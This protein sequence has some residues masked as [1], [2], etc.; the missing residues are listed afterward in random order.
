MRS[1]VAPLLLGCAAASSAA[2][3][4]PAPPK[5]APREGRCR[6]EIVNVDRKGVVEANTNYYGG[7]NVFLRCFGQKVSMKSDSVR[8]IGAGAGQP[9]IVYFIGNVLY[10]DTTMEM[11]ARN[12]T[13]F[14]NGERWEARDNVKTRNLETGSTLDGPSLDY[15]RTAPGI[16]DTAEMYAVG[17]PTIHYVPKSTDGTEEEPYVIIGDRVRMRGDD[18]LWAGGNVTVD[19][20]DFS[21]KSD[22]LQLF[23]SDSGSGVLVGG[24]PVLKGLKRDTFELHGTRIE[25]DLRQRKVTAVRALGE[26]H[27]IRTDLDLTA[28][29]IHMSLPEEKLQQT[30]A[31][32]AAERAHAVGPSYEVRADSLVIDTPEEKLYEVRGFGDGWM[33][34]KPDSGTHERDWIAGDTV[35]ALFVQRDS[36][37]TE[38]TRIAQLEATGSGRT[39]YRGDAKRPGGPR[40]LNYSRADHIVARMKDDEKGGVERVDLNGNV[41]GVQLDPAAASS[42]PGAA[43]AGRSP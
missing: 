4:Q 9:A 7:G 13:Y 27:A 3:Q 10:Q 11:R 23:S 40:P 21:S 22:S 19:R 25:F 36:A 20:S 14:Q 6:L 33:G 17:R 32:G 2:A 43:P 15:L 12:A 8:Y 39:F 35:R 41:D 5:P 26:G 24:E 34:A 38:Q 30:L 31:W 16:R 42:A 37:G 28:D 1:W 29:T 18:K